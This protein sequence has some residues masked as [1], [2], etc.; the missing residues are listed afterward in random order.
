M[1]HLMNSY[2]VIE[3]VPRASALRGGLVTSR[4]DSVTGAD[5]KKTRLVS[6]THDQARINFVWYHYEPASIMPS[7]IPF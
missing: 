6:P 1:V 7:F 5:T 3:I 2:L 4:A